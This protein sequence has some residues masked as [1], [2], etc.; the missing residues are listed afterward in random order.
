MPQQ[1]AQRQ[2]LKLQ[3]AELQQQAARL[4]NATGDISFSLISV[5]RTKPVCI[6]VP[7]CSIY[8]YFSAYLFI[9]FLTKLKFPRKLH[10]PLRRLVEV[11]DSFDS[12]G[13]LVFKSGGQRGL[14]L[15]LVGP[16]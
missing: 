15:F 10:R 2:L 16:F 4:Q 3:Q 13:F 12:G 6:V 11:R 1:Q 14:S 5:F 8:T 9:S 7:L